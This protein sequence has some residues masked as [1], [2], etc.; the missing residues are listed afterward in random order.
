MAKTP[1]RT[2]AIRNHYHGQTQEIVLVSESGIGAY[3]WKVPWAMAKAHFQK[4][5]TLHPDLFAL[6]LGTV[7]DTGRYVSLE[8]ITREAATDE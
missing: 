1:K 3:S 7:E 8:I 2:Y 5:E 4:C 6:E